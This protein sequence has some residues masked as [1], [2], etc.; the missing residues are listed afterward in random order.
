MKVPKKQSISLLE[1]TM[2]TK[3]VRQVDMA[4]IL[5]VDAR[6]IRSWLSGKT[7][8]SPKY[9]RAIVDLSNVIGSLYLNLIVTQIKDSRL[10]KTDLLL[11]IEEAVKEIRRK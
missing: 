5:G 7:V 1:K 3:G 4:S 6:V 9:Y 2:K 10:S 8:M 11:V